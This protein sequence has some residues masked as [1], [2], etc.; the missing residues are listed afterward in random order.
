MLKLKNS[1]RDLAKK[2]KSSDHEQDQKV[3]NN[4]KQILNSF[5]NNLMA[6][7]KDVGK[8]GAELKQ[9][10]CN[11][12]I[13]I[14]SSKTCWEA[15]CEANKDDCDLIGNRPH[16]NDGASFDWSGNVNT[17]AKYFKKSCHFDVLMPVKGKD[18]KDWDENDELDKALNWV[19]SSSEKWEITDNYA[20]WIMHMYLFEKVGSFGNP[21]M[22]F[23]GDFN[24]YGPVRTFKLDWASGHYLEMLKEKGVASAQPGV[25]VFDCGVNTT[26][27]YECDLSERGSVAIR[28]QTVL[29]FNLKGLVYSGQGAWGGDEFYSMIEEK[30]GWLCRLFGECPTLDVDVRR[31][32]REFIRCAASFLA[33]PRMEVMV[34]AQ[35]ASFRWLKML[36]SACFFMF[37]SLSLSSLPQ[38]PP[39]LPMTPFRTFYI[40]LLMPRTASLPN[41]MLS[42]SP[43]AR[44]DEGIG[45]GDVELKVRS[46]PPPSPQVRSFPSLIGLPFSLLKRPHLLT[47]LSLEC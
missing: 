7:F 31:N 17:A 29:D 34:I 24:F 5:K 21:K 13:G 45:L 22:T 37:L 32:R 19:H 30:V 23:T 27:V 26:H 15:I 46:R 6:Y 9:Q 18:N 14:E 33:R 10:A 41:V 2:Y 16:A 11:G 1:L 44:V 35:T 47:V 40:Y 43:M 39:F 20:M 36:H 12:V 3:R 28:L 38:S 8:A 4:F 42:P 25:L